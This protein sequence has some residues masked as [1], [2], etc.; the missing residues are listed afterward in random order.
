VCASLLDVVT[1]EYRQHCRSEYTTN[2]MR[3]KH[4]TR[5]MQCA[6]IRV[7]TVQ[8]PASSHS[9]TRQPP[10]AGSSN[11]HH[12]SLLRP[13]AQSDADAVRWSP[14]AAA[15]RSP[16]SRHAGAR[17]ALLG[18]RAHGVLLLRQ[19]QAHLAFREQRRRMVLPGG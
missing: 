11:V 9:N 12:H 16:E 13:S 5:R 6:A 17:R 4:L 19:A 15:S 14:D 18:V 3:E 8:P 10:S 2:R 1:L 7:V